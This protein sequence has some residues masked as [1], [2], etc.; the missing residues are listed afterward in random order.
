M[1]HQ[2]F[3]PPLQTAVI[4]LS[5]GNKGSLKTP[6]HTLTKLFA[7]IIHFLWVS[8]SIILCAALGVRFM[9]ELPAMN[10]VVIKQVQ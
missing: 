5:T 8:C 2:F 9:F 10:I 7:L 6:L 4:R 3:I 1:Q